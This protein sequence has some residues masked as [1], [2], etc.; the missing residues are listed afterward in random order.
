LHNPPGEEDALNLAE[1]PDAPDALKAEVLELKHGEPE[2]NQW[3]CIVMLL[4]CLALMAATAEW[5]VQSM[6]VVHE[7]S[8]VEE[9]Y[10][11]L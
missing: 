3:V 6:K 8:H 2:V 9:G 1:A 11:S 10:A 4:I 7:A 5:L